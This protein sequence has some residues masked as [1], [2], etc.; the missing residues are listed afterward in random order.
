MGK[1]PDAEKIMR[2]LVDLYAQQTGVE[3]EYIVVDGGA[4]NNGTR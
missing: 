4:E 2:T 1:Q 3:I